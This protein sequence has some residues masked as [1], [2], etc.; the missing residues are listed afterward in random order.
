MAVLADFILKVANVAALPSDNAAGTEG[1]IAFA[2]TEEELYR[3][4]GTTWDQIADIGGGSSVPTLVSD[5]KSVT[6]GNKTVTSTS[7]AV[8][9]TNLDIT[10]TTGARRCL[11]TWTLAGGHTSATGNNAV[12]VEIDGSRVGQTFGL[13]TVYPPAANG[14]FNL[15]GSFVTDTLSAASHTFKL[16]FRVDGGTATLFASTSVCPII[17]SVVELL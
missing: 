5:K 9:D 6:S 8:I 2:T 13:I 17:F 10:L 16:M 3:D 1:R 4:N 15:S 14:N 11:V 7:F 12:D